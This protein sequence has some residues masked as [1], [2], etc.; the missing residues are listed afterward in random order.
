MYRL[1]IHFAMIQHILLI[2]NALIFVLLSL[3]HIYWAAGGKW[4]ATRVLPQVPGA[5]GAKAFTPGK[6]MTL[7]VAAG[8]MGLALIQ[9]GNVYNELENKILTGGLLAT[10]I[11]FGLRVIGDFRYVG[12]TKR[13]RDTTFARN[14]NRIFIPLCLYVALS[15]LFV[16]FY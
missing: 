2:V 8:L 5:G 14:D 3:L 6:G 10:G 7:L 13:V 9:T 4:A 1:I 15:S 11:I 16:Y 12:I